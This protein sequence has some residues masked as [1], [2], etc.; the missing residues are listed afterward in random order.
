VV[1]LDA[2]WPPACK[3]LKLARREG[4]YALPRVGSNP[5]RGAVPA[6]L[7]LKGSGIP[8]GGVLAWI[9]ITIRLLLIK[10]SLQQLIRKSE[11]KVISSSP[12]KESTIV[13]FGSIFA[14]QHKHINF[15]LEIECIQGARLLAQL[16]FTL[17]V[18]SI[19]A[20]P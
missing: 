15:K 12:W 16:S 7:P 14:R 5:E 6:G 1:P 10:K 2:S 9:D 20:L 18:F 8:V 19:T 11:E 17:F 13:A 3:E 4:S